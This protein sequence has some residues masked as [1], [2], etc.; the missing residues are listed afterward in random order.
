VSARP[1]LRREVVLMGPAG[2]VYAWACRTLER[3]G[4]G[5]DW[6]TAHSAW[7]LAGRL[8][9]QRIEWTETSVIIDGFRNVTLQ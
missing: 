6:R 9:A 7:L 5:Q 3:C 2:E 4:F 1:H 8:K